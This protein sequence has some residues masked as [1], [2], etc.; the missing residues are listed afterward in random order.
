MTKLSSA[1]LTNYTVSCEQSNEIVPRNRGGS[2]KS[3]GKIKLL[4]LKIVIA[5]LVESKCRFKNAFC[6]K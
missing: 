6:T 1:I 2:L 5:L 4:N 3:E